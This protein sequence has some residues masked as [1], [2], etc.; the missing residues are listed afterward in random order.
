[1]ADISDWLESIGLGQYTD[2]FEKNA[3]G[4]DVLS[5]LDHGVLK[6]VGVYAAGDR[7]RILYAIKSLRARGG[8][9]GPAPATHASSAG[10]ERR[11]LTVMFCDLAGSTELARRL[12]PE[13]LAELVKAYQS[14]CNAAIERYSGFIA[15]YVGDGILAYFGYPQAH[16]EDAERAIRAA[17][18]IIDG[19]DDV[20]N[21][22]D[23]RPRGRACRPDRH[24]HRAGRRRRS[25]RRGQR[26]RE[27]RA[28]RNA[29]PGLAHARASATE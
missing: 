9:V 13:D 12:D 27:R 20:A 28:R 6:D 3:I 26:A 15:R 22:P 1:M 2:A 5:H 29:K 8:N 11:Q 24:R 10:A 17:L 21:E 14:V 7:V 4:W 19:N 18:G 23:Q 25:D 16:E